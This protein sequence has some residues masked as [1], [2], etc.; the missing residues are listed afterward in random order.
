[1]GGWLECVYAE[2]RE[3]CLFLSDSERE[4]Y[5]ADASREGRECIGEEMDAL[6]HTHLNTQ[7]VQ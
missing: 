5:S 3:L 1:M 7:L 2:I 4:T 6:T